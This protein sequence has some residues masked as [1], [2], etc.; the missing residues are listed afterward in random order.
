MNAF[1]FNDGLVDSIG[2]IKGTPT[3]PDEVLL[4]SP[5]LVD[6]DL[7]DLVDTAPADER[8]SFVFN[9]NAQELDHIL[10]TQN[11]ESRLAGL[12]YG[13]ANADFPDSLRNDAARAERTS[14][15][16]PLVAYFTIPSLSLDDVTVTE[17]DEGVIQARF[18]VTL[19][20]APEND[21]RVRFATEDGGGENGATSGLDYIARDGE[22]TF[23]AGETTQTIVV[24]VI[25]DRTFEPNEFFRVRLSDASSNASLEDA[26]GTGTIANDDP[27]PSISIGDATVGEEHGTAT[28]T[29]SL[30]NPSAFTI[31]VA[32]ETADGTATQPDDYAATAGV[33]EFAPGETTR[34]VKVT[35]ADD[36]LD[37][38]DETFAVNLSNAENATILDG[39]GIGT[40]RD[41][42]PLP[43]LRIRDARAEEPPAGATSLMTF[44]VELSAPSGKTVTVD[45]RTFNLTAVAGRDYR[46]RS[47]T[48]TFAPGETE[49]TIDVQI[50]ADHRREFVEIFLVLLHHPTNAI[51]H[52]AIG[53]GIIEDARKP[54]GRP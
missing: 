27:E 41:N 39:E 7:I 13:R 26:L 19:Q 43:K 54:H 28:F 44:R 23:L 18:T 14:D 42:D 12:Q 37:E 25:G 47:G 31:T 40:I 45:F 50:L 29:A 33:L 9:G 51:A 2:T 48:L 21:V 6:P 22:L 24:D 5:D 36:L 53:I 20:N 3:P 16:D 35:I 10:I 38:P 11:L 8:Y 17:G 46:A 34:T 15:H 49:Q 52:D 1:Q 32:F 4:S 30:S